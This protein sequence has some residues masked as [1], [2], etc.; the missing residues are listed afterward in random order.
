LFGVR[1][2]AFV[3]RIC[4]S[5]DTKYYWMRMSLFSQKKE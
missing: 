5:K 2:I 4:L 1:L 3:I